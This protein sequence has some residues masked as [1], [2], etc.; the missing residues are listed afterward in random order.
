MRRTLRALLAALA[1][2]LGL[3]GVA[4]AAGRMLLPASACAV[5]EAQIEAL[6]LERMSQAEV[7]SALGCA[8][9]PAEM[10]DLGAD[11]TI[12]RV[13]WRG[14]AWPYGVLTAQFINGVLHGTEKVWLDL[15]LSWP[16]GEAAE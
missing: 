12:E 1:G 4:I 15:R 16:S 14:T 6:V 5:N 11:I 2:L 10:T 7:A 3:I 8:G 13:R 9:V